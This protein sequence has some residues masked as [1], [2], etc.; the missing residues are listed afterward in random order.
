[1]VG[2][3]DGHTDAFFYSQPNYHAHTGR[4]GNTY[5]Y[6]HTDGDGHGDPSTNADGHGYGG[7]DANRDRDADTYA[8]SN[9]NCVAYGDV[10]AHIYRDAEHDGYVLATGDARQAISQLTTTTERER[11]LC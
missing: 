8:N 10:C 5:R 9:G 7:T 3:G 11:G 2:A 6:T 4:Y 1:L